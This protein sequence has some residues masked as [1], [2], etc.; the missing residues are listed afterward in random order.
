MAAE[1]LLNTLTRAGL[2]ELLRLRLVRVVPIP[3]PGAGAEVVAT[4][5]AGVVWELLTLRYRFATSAVVANRASRPVVRDADGN[6]VAAIVTP[7]TQAASS[8]LDYDYLAGLG[9]N[10]GGGPTSQPLPAPPIVMLTGWT[11][12][13]VTANIDAGDSYTL[14]SVTVREWS[15]DQVAAQAQWLGRQLPTSITLDREG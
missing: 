15:P 4:V 14:A 6:S 13:T 3:A 9:V 5:P 10:V 12:R 8:T 11:V 2:Y 7:F 1:D